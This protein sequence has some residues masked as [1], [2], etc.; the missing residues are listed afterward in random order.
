MMDVIK[1]IDDATSLSLHMQL[2][3]GFSLPPVIPI[4][5]QVSVKAKEE[6]TLE[7]HAAESYNKGLRAMTSNFYQVPM[8]FRLSTEPEAGGFL[9]PVDPLVAVNHKN[10]VTRRYVAKSERR[11][12]I[13][14]RWSMDD[15]EI[16]ISG[17]LME[18]KDNT[19]S[20]YVQELRRYCEAKESIYVVCD[21]LNTQYDITRI[22]IESCDF[23][24]TKG[25]ENQMFTIKAYSDDLY[26]LL[27]E[28]K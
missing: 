17:V 6:S 21:M 24:F 5:Q 2:A 10:I 20:S 13:K 4:Q 14:E 15:Y 11:G 18:D 16:S 3:T 8:R 27:I 1:K 19:I 22:T 23:P 26:D 12:S 28:R 25:V 7:D 9:L